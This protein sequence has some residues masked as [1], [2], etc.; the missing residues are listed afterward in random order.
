MKVPTLIMS[1]TDD[2]PATGQPVF[3]HTPGADVGWLQIDNACHQTFALGT[4][5][6]LSADKGFHIVDSYALA[7]ARAYLLGDTG[8]QVQGLVDGTPKD[9]SSPAL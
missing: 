4:C 5:P 6:K 7:W 2:G 9:P 8:K 1:G 3:D